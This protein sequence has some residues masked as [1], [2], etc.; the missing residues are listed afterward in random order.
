MYIETARGVANS[1]TCVSI[2]SQLDW[3]TTDEEAQ[4]SPASDMSLDSNFVDIIN[5]FLPISQASGDPPINGSILTDAEQGVLEQDCVGAIVNT[6]D[7]SLLDLNPMD[8][9]PGF[10]DPRKHTDT[11]TPAGVPEKKFKIDSDGKSQDVNRPL[12]ED[13]Q[14]EASVNKRLFLRSSS[15]EGYTELGSRGEP[16]NAPRSSPPPNDSPIWEGTNS[17]KKSV[18]DLKPIREKLTRELNVESDGVALEHIAK[19]S[20]RK[21][22]DR[23]ENANLRMTLLHEDLQLL[24][25]KKRR[26]ELEM[27]MMRKRMELNSLRR[28]GFV[29]L[30]SEY[31]TMW[32]GA[33]LINS[34]PRQ[35]GS[36]SPALLWSPIK[37]RYHQ[38]EGFNY[39]RPSIRSIPR[40]YRHCLDNYVSRNR[41]I[42][43]RC[44]SRDDS[45]GSS[46]L[47]S[48]L[49]SADKEAQATLQEMNQPNPIQAQEI[50]DSFRYHRK[51]GWEE[52]NGAKVA[53]NLD[54]S[55][56]GPDGTPALAK[57]LKS[58]QDRDETPYVL[59]Q[60]L[61]ID[62]KNDDNDTPLWLDIPERG[63]SVTDIREGS[64]FGHSVLNSFP[65]IAHDLQMQACLGEVGNIGG[66]SKVRLSTISSV[67]T[68]SHTK[69]TP[70]NSLEGKKGEVRDETSQGPHREVVSEN[71]EVQGDHEV[72]DNNDGN[73]EVSTEAN[74]LAEGIQGNVGIDQEDFTPGVFSGNLNVGNA[75]IAEIM[76]PAHDRSELLQS[77]WSNCRVEIRD[78]ILVNLAK[79]VNNSAPLYQHVGAGP[80]DVELRERFGSR[81]LRQLVSRAI[82]E[83]HI[84]LGSPKAEIT[85]HLKQLND[86]PDSEFEKDFEDMMGWYIWPEEFS[87]EEF[88]ATSEYIDQSE[89]PLGPQSINRQILRI[90]NKKAEDRTE[91][92]KKLLRQRSWH[93]TKGLHRKRGAIYALSTRSILS[94]LCGGCV[95]DGIKIDTPFEGDGITGAAMR[96]PDTRN[97]HRYGDEGLEFLAAWA[98]DLLSRYILSHTREEAVMFELLGQWKLKQRSLQD[99]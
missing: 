93:T 76:R 55:D 16:V 65:F 70:T 59:H 1:L 48:G 19:Y 68:R 74:S 72:S 43:E 96:C 42:R 46:T 83:T 73:S 92:E 66:T 99:I 41:Q 77:W 60:D 33:D 30:D 36:T 20:R 90:L 31:E 79:E 91:D 13:R 69:D 14:A 15:S 58:V 11:G 34:K 94:F 80:F 86:R 47:E 5:L 27:Q 82:R 52:A 17:Q 98:Y 78:A 64:S 18:E 67:V 10:G 38:S 61:P 12:G 35:G 6:P 51:A 88:T 25:L 57:V 39:Q 63:S 44:W 89:R 21:L 62:D 54:D 29:V 7:N 49:H 45:R 8:A 95:L 81:M 24:Y 84:Q 40:K 37:P 97:H 4:I 56:S 85:S 71:E 3:L 32:D 23:S 2:N 87:A 22:P 53:E 26:L 75:G 9:S 50:A 28:R